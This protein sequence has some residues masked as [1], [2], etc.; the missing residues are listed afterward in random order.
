MSH[1]RWYLTPAGPARRP[2]TAAEVAADGAH[3]AASAARATKAEV[4]SVRLVAL[5]RKC[6]KYS[7]TGADAPTAREL[8]EAVAR[9]V[10]ALEADEE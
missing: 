9:I 8:A 1:D 2:A 5:A 7:R 10:L 3:V 4:S 6:A